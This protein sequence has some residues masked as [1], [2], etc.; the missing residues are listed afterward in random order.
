MRRL[1]MGRPWRQTQG[2]LRSIVELFG[3]DLP[4]PDHMTL[5]GR[6]ARLLLTTTLKKPKRP[7]TVVID[8]SGL[9]IFEVGEWPGRP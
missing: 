5:S 2:L 9:K 7:V 8:C 6:S 4:V 1:T 3:L